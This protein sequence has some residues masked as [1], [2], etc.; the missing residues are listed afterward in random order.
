MG[1]KSG[2][3]CPFEGGELS[4]YLTQCGQDRGLPAC[5]VSCW[6]VQPFRHST[7][8]SQTGQTYRTTAR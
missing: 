3:V 1:R 5:Q 6:F 4:A 8:T 2:A 7:P